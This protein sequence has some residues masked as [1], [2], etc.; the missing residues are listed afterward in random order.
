MKV[1]NHFRPAIMMAYPHLVKDE[2]TGKSVQPPA[3]V[4]IGASDIPVLRNVLRSALQDAAPSRVHPEYRRL[5]I[6]TQDG[7][8]GVASFT[9][10][11]RGEGRVRSIQ[12]ARAHDAKQVADAAAREADRLE[13]EAAEARQRAERAGTIAEQASAA[14]GE[15][16]EA[17]GMTPSDLASETPEERDARIAAERAAEIQSRKDAEKAQRDAE[18]D[19]EK[20]RAIVLDEEKAWERD[21]REALREIA[22]T[23][24]KGKAFTKEGRNRL[25]ELAEQS[26]FAL[27]GSE[28]AGAL[29]EALIEHERGARVAELG[30]IDERVLRGRDGSDLPDPDPDSD[31]DQNTDPDPDE[32]SLKVP[33]PADQAHAPD[34]E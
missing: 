2:E 8:R 16:L 28:T 15:E 17:S 25:F 34:A 20:I 27:G 26:G 33:D 11:E 24:G 13:R 23:G 9:S 19:K 21:R 31:P 30:T 1:T 6:W 12:K 32:E 22:T 7:V 29:I 18:A 5:E 10:P 14:F 3:I 4:L